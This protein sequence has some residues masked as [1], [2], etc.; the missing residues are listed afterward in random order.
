MAGGSTDKI[1]DAVWGSSGLA[2]NLVPLGNADG[3]EFARDFV[4]W[5]R[6]SLSASATYLAT[7]KAGPPYAAAF[8]L[9]NRF[10]ALWNIQFKV[11]AE[12]NAINVARDY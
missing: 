12:R 11:L 2:L 7:G 4:N 10:A 8:D 1:F 9:A 5:M 3:A 6:D